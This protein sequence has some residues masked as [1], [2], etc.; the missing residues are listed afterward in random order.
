MI[1]TATLTSWLA[2]LDNKTETIKL[3]T[4]VGENGTNA[5]L[6]QVTCWR[7]D[8]ATCDVTLTARDCC[9]NKQQTQETLGGDRTSMWFRKE[10][11]R[12]A[13]NSVFHDNCDPNTQYY[14][15]ERQFKVDEGTQRLSMANESCL[16]VL[17][18]ETPT[19]SP[20]VV[21]DCSRP[22]GRFVLRP[23]KHLVHLHHPQWKGNGR[24]HQ[25]PT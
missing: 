17:H 7:A 9:G 24:R 25:L 19:K 12:F 23:D 21:G 4:I 15:N 11:L 8:G 1:G 18:P 2:T 13:A 10:N 6:T 14:N 16:W 22:E 3:Q 20:I 5:V